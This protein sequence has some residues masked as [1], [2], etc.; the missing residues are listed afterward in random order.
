LRTVTSISNELMEAMSDIVWAIN[1]QKDYLSDLSQRMRRYASDMMTAR[2]IAFRFRAPVSGPEVQLGANVRREVFLIFKES[3]NNVV[4]HAECSEVK[5]DLSVEA[6]WL[7][8]RISDNG[9]GFNQA[10]V[11][12]DTG[13]LTSQH[14]GGNGLAS[15]RR[16]ARE[17]GGQFEIIT[18]RGRGTR[19]SLRLPIGH[20]LPAATGAA[21]H[22][23]GDKPASL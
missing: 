3:I 6:D 17:L 19:M 20:T 23:G 22:V 9:K 8:L 2:R 12:A 16:R 14:H 11:K 4:K 15:M 10:L 18:H 1:P 13:F 7:T 21:I 5:L